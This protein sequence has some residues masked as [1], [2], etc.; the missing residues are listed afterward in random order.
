ME[1][2][3]TCLTRKVPGSPPGQLAEPPA[4]ILEGEELALP[5]A[6]DRGPSGTERVGLALEVISLAVEQASCVVLCRP[7]GGR[8]KCQW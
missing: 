8:M 4:L 1:G 7:L 2:P 3:L 5:L 6:P